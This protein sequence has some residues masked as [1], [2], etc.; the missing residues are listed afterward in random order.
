[1]DPERAAAWT[2]GDLARALR[3]SERTLSRNAERL[4]LDEA[5]VEISRRTIRYSVSR[6][7]NRE[8]FRRLTR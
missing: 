8:W 1:V 6:M 2:R 3:T 4:G 7:Q 5:R